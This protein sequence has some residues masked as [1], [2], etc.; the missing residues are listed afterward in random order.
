MTTQIDALLRLLRDD[1]PATLN[2]LKGQLATRGVSALPEMRAL[3][4]ADDPVVARHVRDVIAQIESDEADAS[5]GKFC[6]SFGRDGDLEE[7]AWRLAAV[8]MPGEDFASQRALL[9]AW[10][11]EVA[12]RLVGV[13]SEL[14]R[15]ETLVEF[16]GDD[17]GL[18]G[19]AEDYDNINNSLLPEVIDTRL[20]IPITLSLVY[21]VVGRRAGIPV[22]GAGLPGHFLIRYG[23][24]FFDPFH[25]GARVGLDECRARVAQHGLKLSASTLQPFPAPQFLARM[26][27]NIHTVAEESDPP[28]AAKVSR[29]IDLIVQ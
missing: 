10:G 9:D 8:F 13:E 14:D 16:L 4:A 20:G 17:V 18:R 7:A 26:L 29:W 27:N 28:L 11:A 3:L 25:G 1:D 2:L 6:A 15:I 21:I 12:R 23:Q 24:N 5:F 22:S 19:N